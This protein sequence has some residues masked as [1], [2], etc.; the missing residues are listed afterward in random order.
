MK[1]GIDCV[2]IFVSGICHD[3]KGNILYRRRGPGARDEIGKWD[4]GAGGSLEF[5]ETIETC[6]EREIVEEVGV[7]ILQKEY[8][9]MREA[10]RTLSGNKTHW[11]GFYYKCLI[12][13]KKARISEDEEC[14]AMVW[15]SFHKPQSP[16]MLGQEEVY[17]MFKHKF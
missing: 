7:E 2:G 5:G 1:K 10:F 9:G 12:D 6:L 3:G 14:D 13:P 8:L 11:V 16:R 17:E 15:D 4:V